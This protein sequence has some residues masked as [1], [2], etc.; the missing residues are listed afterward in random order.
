MTD[1]W[2]RIYDDYWRGESHAHVYH[3]DDGNRDTASADAYFVAPRG[4]ADHGML[5]ELSGRI[6][7]LGCGPGSYTLFLE[8][9]GNA[10][11]AVDSSPG[12]ITVCR[13]RGCRD[14]RALGIDDVDESVGRFDAIVCMG[15][16][17]GI[18]SSPAHLPQRLDRMRR[19]LSPSGRLVL[20]LLDPLSTTDP[21]HLAY[22]DRNRA[23][24]RPPGLARVR[25]EYRGEAGDWWELWMPTEVELRDGADAAGWFVHRMVPEGTSCLWDLAPRAPG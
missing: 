22:H 9:R 14:A 12:A 20:A 6:L 17:F 7:D 13:E 5:S 2:G 24:G 3:R 18:G 10:V 1:I 16:T 21:K 11:V 15:N 8:S 4:I 19:L 23:A 25:L